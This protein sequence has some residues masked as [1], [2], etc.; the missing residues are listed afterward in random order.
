MAKTSPPFHFIPIF[1]AHQPSGNFEYVF[2]ECYRNGYEAFLSLLEEH[3]KIHAGLH[4]S[5]PLLLWIEKHHADYF[6]RLRKLVRSGRVEILGG[7]FYEPILISIPEADQIEQLKLLSAYIEKHF[8]KPPTGAWLAERV[9]EPQ[10]PSPLAAANISYTMID[11]LPF[12]AAGF[13]PD[14]LFGV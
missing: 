11:D 9:W 6:E 8:G 1:H 5:G 3:P 13:E 4:Y 14:E 7:G 10:L 2:E 12:L